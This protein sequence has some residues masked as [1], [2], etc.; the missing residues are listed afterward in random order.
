MNTKVAHRWGGKLHIRCVVCGVDYGE[1]VSRLSACPGPSPA[2]TPWKSTD[3]PPQG[4]HY[5]PYTR[6]LAENLT[7]EEVKQMWPYA[8]PKKED[9]VALHDWTRTGTCLECG[10]GFASLD[11][12]DPCPGKKETPKVEPV[13]EW[14]ED[15]L[16]QVAPKPDPTELH[17]APPRRLLTKE[18]VAANRVPLE[19]V[20]EVVNNML[21]AAD[22]VV[23][24]EH[25]ARFK[26]EPIRFIC[27]NNLNFFQG[28]IIKYVLRHDAKNGLEDLKKARR[29]LDMFIKFVEGDADWW[30]KDAT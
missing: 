9:T 6:A 19:A 8:K 13:R 17:S 14:L 12:Q 20:G 25:Y 30:R 28:N 24:P 4:F 21:T 10:C 3:K 29:Y 15:A 27:E 23:M 11:R 22:M 16:E 18:D 5:D 7:D 26:I 2:G 1:K